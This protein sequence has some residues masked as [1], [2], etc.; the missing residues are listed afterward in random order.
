MT[1][2]VLAVLA[3]MVSLFAALAAGLVWAQQGARQLSASSTEVS[4]RSDVRF[5][6]ARL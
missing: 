4:V 2:A 5:N 3:T 1:P 6:P